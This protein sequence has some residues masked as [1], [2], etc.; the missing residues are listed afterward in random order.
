MKNPAMRSAVVRDAKAQAG[1]IYRM[2]A[3]HADRYA[4]T[5]HA[6]GKEV[7][8]GMFLNRHESEACWDGVIELATKKARLAR[9]A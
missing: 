5:V 6:N 7:G 3:P 1:S 9:P 8:T 2:N 4:Y